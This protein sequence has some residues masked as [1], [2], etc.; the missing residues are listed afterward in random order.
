MSQSVGLNFKSRIPQFS[1]DAS[2]EE[3][4]KVYHYGVDN[5]STQPIPNDSI[6][7]NFRSLDDRLIVV[8]DAL[9][10]L[11]VTFIEATSSSSSPNTI[12]PENSSTIPLTIKGVSSQTANLQQWQ[13]N[14]STN[15]AV[16]FSNG[17][18]SFGGYVSVGATAQSTTTANS[19][20]IGNAAHKGITV[21]A[22]SSQSAN[23]QEWQDSSG[24][25]M[26]W[27][28]ADGKIYQQGTQV[29][30]GSGDLTSN[31]LLMGS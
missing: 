24:T 3:A 27:V 26:S 23:V 31:F 7:G 30:S 21:K 12:T 20:T 5:Y 17:A 19:I 11:A 6:E 15:L 29:G 28:T 14:S 9:D 25:A 18:A 16:V 2:I 1:D 4:L 13:D 10:N 22:A 8:E